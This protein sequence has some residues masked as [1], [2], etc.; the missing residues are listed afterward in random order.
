MASGSLES[1]LLD[2]S[3]LRVG[4]SCIRTQ[5]MQ[6]P[7]YDLRN[8]NAA[9]VNLNVATLYTVTGYNG[10]RRKQPPESALEVYLMQGNRYPEQQAGCK[11]AI[12]SP[13][14]QNPDQQP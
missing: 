10:V 13:E 14:Y 2:A 11:L 3:F 7:A 6:P 8:I 5:R 4:L 1:H 12:S 9:Y